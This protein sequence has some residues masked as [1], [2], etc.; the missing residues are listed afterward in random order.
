M[1]P[2][3]PTHDPA[4]LTEARAED[5][6]AMC[7]MVAELCAVRGIPATIRDPGD[8]GPRTA[9]VRIEPP[10]GPHV[11]VSFDGGKPRARRD[12]YLLSWHMGAIRNR[13]IAPCFC[14]VAQINIYH[15]RKATD[16]VRGF[17]GLLAL[18][19]SRLERIAAGTATEPVPE[20]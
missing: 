14:S 9:D 15:R 12:R 1:K 17:D 10:E 7:R 16:Y 20:P 6:A 5:R 4:T 11:T 18:L 13:C 2:T 8:F 19:A 3:L